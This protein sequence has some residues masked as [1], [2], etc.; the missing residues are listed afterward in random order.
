MINELNTYWKLGT[1]A[2]KEVYE[3]L[4]CHEPISSVGYS[5]KKRNTA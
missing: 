4:G 3:D 1:H 5:V 2:G